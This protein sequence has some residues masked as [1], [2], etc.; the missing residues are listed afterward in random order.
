MKQFKQGKIDWSFFLVFDL[1]FFI[2]FFDK[3]VAGR[4]RDD[5][6]PKRTKHNDSWA[7]CDQQDTIL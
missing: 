4:L 3:I 7:Q 6:S 1:L 5:S 2:F